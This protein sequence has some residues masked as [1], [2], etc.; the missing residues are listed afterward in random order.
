MSNIHLSIVIP[1]YNEA[2]G[3]PLL[4]QRLEKLRTSY[5]DIGFIVVNNGST[6]TSS[7]VLDALVLAPGITRIDIAKNQGY[8]HGIL[9]G[10]RIADTPFLGWTHADLQTDPEDVARLW[11]AMQKHPNT[12]VFGKGKR[13][14]RPLFDVVFTVG[15]SFF[16]SLFLRL[17]LWDINAQPT[18]FHR[19][20][21]ETWEHP[22]EDFSLD[23]YAY[24]LAKKQKLTVMRQSVWF[25][26]RPFG[27]SSWNTGLTGK[28]RFIKRTLAFSLAL[29]KRL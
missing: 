9:S 12:A 6:D 24:A 5:P 10:L 8:G 4:M 7:A 18:L 26:K 14:G 25:H 3:L 15:M 22:P 27:Q 29:R 17:P 19:D 1:C 21:F 2:Q 28:W 13:L 20:F 11:H 16:E 23:L